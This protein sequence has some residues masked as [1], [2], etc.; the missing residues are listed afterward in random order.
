MDDTNPTPR[1]ER[2]TPTAAC[3]D[4]QT[5]VP[6]P[7]LDWAL[8]EFA[9]LR[10]RCPACGRRWSEIHDATQVERFGALH[11]PARVS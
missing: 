1:P 10:W 7:A 8:L 6:V 9:V 4:C 5:P 3:P 2:S 11:A